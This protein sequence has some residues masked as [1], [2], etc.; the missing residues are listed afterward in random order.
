MNITCPLGLE[1]AKAATKAAN[2]TYESTK[3]SL[4]SGVIHA[5]A[6]S[7]AKRAMAAISRALSASDEKNCA[8]IMV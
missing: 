5:G 1:S 3:K 7:W 8:A 6:A 2:Y 4:R